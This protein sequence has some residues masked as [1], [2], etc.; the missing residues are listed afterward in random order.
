VKEQHAEA[1]NDLITLP[2]NAQTIFLQKLVLRWCAFYLLHPLSHCPV[3]ESRFAAE[4]SQLL[5]GASSSLIHLG[6]LFQVSDALVTLCSSPQE[7]HS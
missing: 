4:S 1:Q 7:N 6:W 2:L 3:H 5:W